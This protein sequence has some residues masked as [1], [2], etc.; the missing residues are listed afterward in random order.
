MDKNDHPFTS[1]EKIFSK[2]GYANS[3]EETYFMDKIRCGRFLLV[4]SNAA[5]QIEIAE[6]QIFAVLKNNWLI[7][8]DEIKKIIRDY[9]YSIVLLASNI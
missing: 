5:V 8:F 6:L 9:W 1:Y 7:Q 3:R 4:K 2:I